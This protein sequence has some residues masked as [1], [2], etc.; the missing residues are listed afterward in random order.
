MCPPVAM[1][2]IE[3][4][5]AS[6]LAPGSS[7]TSNC[8]PSTAKSGPSPKSSAKVLWTCPIPLPITV[9]AP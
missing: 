7:R 3:S 5:P 4:G 2:S 8:E 6:R 9:F 1:A